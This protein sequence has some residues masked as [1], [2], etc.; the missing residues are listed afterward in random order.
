MPSLRTSGPRSVLR[1]TARAS[2]EKGTNMQTFLSKIAAPVA[3]TVV[4]L[5]AGD[6]SAQQ[7]PKKDLVINGPYYA[8]LVQMKDLVADIL[9]PPAYIIETYLT[10]LQITDALDS[11]LADG[12]FSAAEK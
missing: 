12:S 6:A 4:A 3:L 5:L 11:S 10:V 2:L 9:P 8:Q 7:V 1:R